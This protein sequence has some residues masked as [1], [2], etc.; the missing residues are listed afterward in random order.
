MKIP[1]NPFVRTAR[2]IKMSFTFSSIACLVIGLIL[3]LMPNLSQM[4]LCTAVGIGLILYG[5]FNI[6]SFLLEGGPAYTLELLIGI[7]ATALGVFS[8]INPLFLMNFLFTALGIMIMVGSICGIRRA[9]NLRAFGFPQWWA[10][11]LSS[12]ITL[13]VALSIVL[14]PNAYGNTLMMVIGIVLIVEAVSDL[15]AIYRLSRLTRGL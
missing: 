5:V 3:L 4:V 10:A 13:L 15:L 14:F 11:M 9:L 1:N 12:C 2:E 8:L 7:A 6:L